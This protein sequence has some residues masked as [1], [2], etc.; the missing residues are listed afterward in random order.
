M[1]LTELPPPSRSARPVSRKGSLGRTRPATLA[2]LLA[3]SALF[4][5]G[6]DAEPARFAS[7][8]PMRP[9]PV[10][11]HRPRGPG[12]AH[13]VDP[14]VG[15][16]RSEGSETHPWRT[17][18]HAVVQLHPGDT[19]YLRGGTYTEHVTVTASGAPDKPM[20][21]RSYPGELAIIDGG[22]REF[23]ESPRTAWNPCPAGAQ[24]EFWSVNT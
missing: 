23:F 18:Q 12:P 7:H 10:A 15:D 16:D 14:K 24:G 8:P 19:L 2:A 17:L 20:T 3:L 5:D 22:L 4:P 9:L 6:G 11:S 21:I 13:F 1:R